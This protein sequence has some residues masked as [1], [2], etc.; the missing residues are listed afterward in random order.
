MEITEKELLA[1]V[2][3]MENIAYELKGRSFVLETDHRA[4]EAIKIKPEFEKDDENQPWNPIDEI[5]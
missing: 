1:V 4:L 2:F 3:D 5:F